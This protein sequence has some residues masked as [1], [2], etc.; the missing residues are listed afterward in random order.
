MP[1]RFQH[2]HISLPSLKSLTASTSIRQ[3]IGCG[4]AITLAVA[5]VGT[6]FGNMVDAFYRDRAVKKIT[7][8]SQE[9][10]R[11]ADWKTTI[12]QIHLHEHQFA[13]L[14]MKPEKFE[15]D[16]RDLLNKVNHLEILLNQSQS[17]L[18]YLEAS[19]INVEDRK[20]YQRFNYF[21]IKY[22]Q[23]ISN[24]LIE[25]KAVMRQIPASKMRPHDSQKAQ[26]LFRNFINSK[27]ALEF[28][29]V[30]DEVAQLAGDFFAAEAKSLDIFKQ[31]SN[32][33]ALILITSLLISAA[34][35]S[36]VAL[37]I[38]RAIAHPIEL[39]TAVAQQ[40]TETA[41]F[42]LSAPVTTNDEIGKLTNSLNQLIRRIAEYTE[43]LDQTQAQLIQTEKMS[44]LGQMV[45]G[46]AHEVNNPINFIHGNL[47]HTNTYVQDV[48]ELIR[49]YQQEY[50]LPTANIQDHLEKIDYKFIAEDLP[51]TLLSMQ[52]GTQRIR[53]LVLSLRN[54]SRLDEADVKDVDL[55][56]GIDNTLLILNHRVKTQIEV[57]KHYGNLPL[58]E[59]YPA[60]LNQVFMNLLSNAIDALESMPDDYNKQIAIAT[61]FVPPDRVKVKIWDNGAGIA[62]ELKNKI[63][64]LF[65]TTKPVGKGTG[66][67]LSICYQIIKKHNGS[68]QVN[69]EV[70]KGTEFAIFL[71]VQQ[72]SPMQNNGLGLRHSVLN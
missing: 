55:H 38:S 9:A 14:D 26:Q 10:N 21:I 54:F 46:I 15:Q 61:E 4:F 17:Y 18:K 40:V 44:S 41:N 42:N 8:A 32:L 67:G 25:L 2:I 22:K 69:S 37:R 52:I 45:A 72:S 30:S 24:Y 48:I 19:N 60:Q 3:K 23:N 43:E 66:L 34:I 51:K 5:T 20:K 71:P 29:R 57:I 65:F 28:D 59:C 62:P 64:D 63:F 6:L 35:A 33:H 16:Y 53:H 13:S 47:E 58:I 39:T 11:L 31:A 12:L 49:L 36:A 68:M 70:G 27:L 1:S 56:E 50:P 7:F